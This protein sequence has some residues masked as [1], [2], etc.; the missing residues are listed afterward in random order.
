MSTRP[1]T[2]VSLRICCHPSVAP[3]RPD[4]TPAASRVESSNPGGGKGREHSAGASQNLPCIPQASCGPDRR[5]AQPRPHR[6]RAVT[7]NP[8]KGGKSPNQARHVIVADDLKAAAVPSQ[9]VTE[10]VS[11]NCGNGHAAASIVPPTSYLPAESG[12]PIPHGIPS[13]GGPAGHVHI[14]FHEEKRAGFHNVYLDRIQPVAGGDAADT[15]PE[16]AAW[17]TAV[18]ATPW[19][20]GSG[21]P[22]REVPPEE[23]FERLKPF[24]DRVADDIRGDQE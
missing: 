4:A 16:E 9:K 21:E 20:V 13:S 22:E 24:K 19:L 1:V 12:R 10:D 14:E 11:A 2:V 6:R 23:L 3:T 8:A 5:Q 17:R 7:H 18:E 15:D